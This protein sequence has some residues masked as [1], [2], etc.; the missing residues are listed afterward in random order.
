MILSLLELL[1][2]YSLHSGNVSL[3]LTS[4]APRLIASRVNEPLM[5]PMKQLRQTLISNEP[6]M[7][8]GSDHAHK[9]NADRV[10]NIKQLITLKLLYSCPLLLWLFFLY[11]KVRPQ[12]NS[13]YKVLL[14]GCRSAVWRHCSLH[15]IIMKAQSIFLSEQ[16]ETDSFYIIL[17]FLLELFVEGYKLVFLILVRLGLRGK[18]FAQ[19]K[20]SSEKG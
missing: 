17:D 5:S 14:I 1:H 6:S 9:L 20:I 12:G 4:S 11:L 8:S 3:C 16:D 13:L 10:L 18:K 19:P 7:N 15:S 2:T